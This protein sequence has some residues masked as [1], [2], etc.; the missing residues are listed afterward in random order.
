MRS[1]LQQ[2]NIWLVL[3]IL[4][5]SH[6]GLSIIFLYYRDPFPP[7]PVILTTLWDDNMYG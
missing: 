4:N 3:F 1:A 5:Y 7:S 6:Q 2:E